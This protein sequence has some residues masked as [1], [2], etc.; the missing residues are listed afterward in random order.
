MYLG[1]KKKKATHLLIDGL[2]VVSRSQTNK[3]RSLFLF[4]VNDDLLICSLISRAVVEPRYRISTLRSREIPKCSNFWPT[5]T[6]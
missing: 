6:S 2:R 1:K 3:I 4:V 5:M